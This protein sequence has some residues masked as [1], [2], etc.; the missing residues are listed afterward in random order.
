MPSFYQLSRPTENDAAPPSKS[1]VLLILCLLVLVPGLIT[2]TMANSNEWRETAIV[3]AII[4]GGIIIAR[5][6]WGLLIFI[7][8]LYTRPEESINE[9]AGLR[10]PLIVS[11]VTLIATIF[12]KL[13]GREVFA[14]TPL[15][16]MIFG[17]GASAVL[18]AMSSGLTT[19]AAQDVGRLVILVLLM[20]NLVNTPKRYQQVS[21]TILAFTFY[22]AGYSIYLYFTGGAL[23]EHG[24]L[25]SQATGIFSDPNDTA[26]T[27]V[28]GLGLALFRA[29][30]EQKLLRW[31]YI[32]VSAIFFWAILLTNSRGGM[33]AL[34]LLAIIFVFLTVRNK[35]KALSILLVAVVPLMLLSSSRMRNFDVGDESANQRFWYWTNGVEQLIQNPLLGVGYQGFSEVNGGMTAHN[36]FVL[37]FAET[38]LIGYFFWMGC[39]YYSFRTSQTNAKSDSDSNVSKRQSLELL[40]TRVAL[41]GFLASAF[42]ISRTYVP[43]LYLLIS[44]PITQQLVTSPI[45]SPVDSQ[46]QAREI[47]SDGLGDGVRIT[48][49]CLG[50]ILAIYIYALRNR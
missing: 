11:V 29:R 42:W 5:P 40:G 43:I 31:V 46:K 33:L 45:T 9:L 39:L 25:R 16:G 21:T 23:N 50:S 18:S 32:S 48:L 36:S 14:K 19:I 37:C 22:L 38:G 27:I 47:A 13:L 17:F 26:G 34:M 12:Q 15:N 28:A 44:L 49:I 2:Y 8:L 41:I 1:P 24:L 20:V 30:M 7:A 6:F 10:I 3:L 4:A 35:L